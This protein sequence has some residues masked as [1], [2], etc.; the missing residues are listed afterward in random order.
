MRAKK[1]H[2]Y[3][4]TKDINLSM[5]NSEVVCALPDTKIFI[6]EV[7]SPME[8]PKYISI[9]ETAKSLGFKYVWHCSGNF[10]V[11]WRNG[12]KAHSVRYISDLNTILQSLGHSNLTNPRSIDCNG[13]NSQRSIVNQAIES[14]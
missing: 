10:L 3:F 1:L 5:L 12:T 6:N 8:R 9:K 14:N 2:N 11:R 13:E 4:S 7:L